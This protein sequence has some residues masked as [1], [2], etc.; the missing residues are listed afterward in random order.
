MISIGREIPAFGNTKKST[1]TNFNN[2]QDFP[3][4]QNIS[5]DIQIYKMVYKMK[6]TFFKRAYYEDSVIRD[7]I[8]FPINLYNVIIGRRLRRC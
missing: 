7:A 3:L 1:A 8:A 5:L 4:P 6:I 2:P